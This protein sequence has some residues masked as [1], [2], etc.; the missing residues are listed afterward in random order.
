MVALEET[1]AKLSKV[2]EARWKANASSDQVDAA[3]EAVLLR[4]HFEEMQRLDDVSKYP[5]TFRQM[6]KESEQSAWLIE[7]MLNPYRLNV[8]LSQ[9]KPVHRKAL[10]VNWNVIRANCTACH[11]QFRD[12]GATKP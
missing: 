11:K 2:A 9:L 3:H 4:E 10:D 1:V 5:P 8:E 12:N 6:L 7:S